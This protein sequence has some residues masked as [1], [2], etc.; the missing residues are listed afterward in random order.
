MAPGYWRIETTS[1]A[2][3]LLVLAETAYPGWQV[4]VDGERA[5]PLRAYTA[6]RAVCV[7]A[8]THVVEWQFAPRIY[9]LGGGISLLA[10]VL[11]L[12]AGRRLGKQRL[13]A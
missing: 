8:G 4:R 7:P 2:P 3:A 6:V 9:W 11:A 1:A 12:L 13:A 10:L 5:E